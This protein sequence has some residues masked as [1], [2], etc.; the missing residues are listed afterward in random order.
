MADGNCLNSREIT[1]GAS[2]IEPPRFSAT[3]RCELSE[4]FDFYILALI[5]LATIQGERR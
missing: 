1:L 2:A 5:R 3:G 4:T